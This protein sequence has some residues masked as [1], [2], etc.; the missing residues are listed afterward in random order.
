MIHITK[1]TDG[2]KME[3]MQS[4]NT[5]SLTN[6]FCISSS[7]KDMI[8]KSCYGNRQLR[9][10]DNMKEALQRNSILLSTTE[11]KEAPYI[12]ANAFRFNSFGELINMTHFKN[13][14]FIASEN[15]GTTFTLWTKRFKLVQSCFNKNSKPDNLILIHSSYRVNHKEELPEGFDKVFTVYDKWFASAN[16]ITINCHSRCI[17]CRLCYTKN[18]TDSIREIKR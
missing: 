7:K 15:P 5:N 11:L 13:L 16:N 9:M 2:R 14:C 10:Y 4:I 1:H 12:N 6:K 18:I 17:E 8:C 3:G